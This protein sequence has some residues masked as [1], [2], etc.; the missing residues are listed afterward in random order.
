[1][2]G[3]IATNCDEDEVFC[4]GFEARIG[5]GYEFSVF[6]DRWASCDGVPL[7]RGIA[8]GESGRSWR[9]V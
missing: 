7:E 9:A 1:M 8:V 4:W 6:S 3:E 5:Y 2:L